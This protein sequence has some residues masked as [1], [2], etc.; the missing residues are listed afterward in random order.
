MGDQKYKFF[1]NKPKRVNYKV[2][3]KRPRKT[4]EII[5]ESV[6]KKGI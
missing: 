3:E 2:K 4:W 6:K 5:K 1:N